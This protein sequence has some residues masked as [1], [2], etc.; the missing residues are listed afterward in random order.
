MVYRDTHEKVM[1]KYKIMLEGKNFLLSSDGQTMK[2][3]FF[4]T[5]WVEARDPEEAELKAIDLIKN[6]RGLMNNLLNDQS[7][8]PMIY[9]REIYELESFDGVSPPGGGYM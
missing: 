1:K 4:T 3:G 5:R 9:L 7:N 6:D 8:P 2:H